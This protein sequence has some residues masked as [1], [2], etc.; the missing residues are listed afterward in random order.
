M[1]RRQHISIAYYSVFLYHHHPM[2]GE[3]TNRRCIG[4]GYHSNQGSSTF[5]S[6]SARAMVGTW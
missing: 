3:A 4:L 2:F 5:W 6:L 1:L